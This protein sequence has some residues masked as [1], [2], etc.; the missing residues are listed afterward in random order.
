[1]AD[2]LVSISKLAGG[3]VGHRRQTAEES[4]PPGSERRDEVAQRGPGTFLASSKSREFLPTLATLPFGSRIPLSRGK[5][6]K[7]GVAQSPFCKLGVAG[8]IP[9]VS[10]SSK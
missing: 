7:T 1:V 2:Y 5:S 3:F 10:T 4:D 9:F 6:Q 8:S